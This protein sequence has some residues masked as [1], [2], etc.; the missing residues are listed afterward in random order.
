[1]HAFVKIILCVSII[2][3]IFVS[4]VRSSWS[5]RKS[6]T[7]KI[8]LVYECDPWKDGT[9]M[10]KIPVFSGAWQIV[11]DCKEHEREAV[12]I[13]MVFFYKEWISTFGDPQGSVWRALDNL[14]IEWTSISRPVAAHD[15]SGRFHK[16]AHAAGMTLTPTVIWVKPKIGAPVCETSLIHELVHVAIWSIKLTDGDPDHLGNKYSGWSVDH[17]ALIQRLNDHLCSIGI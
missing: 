6:T 13:S 2:L 16:N 17:S 11:E 10:I 5:P 9:Q 7:Q 14:M 3:A 15:I 1:M 8:N 12:A 4:C